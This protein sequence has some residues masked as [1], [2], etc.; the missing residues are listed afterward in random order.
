MQINFQINS[1]NRNSMKKTFAWAL[2]LLT[3]LPLLATASSSSS[4]DFYRF[5]PLLSS[6]PSPN[7]D[8]LLVN[9]WG[10]VITSYGNV[11]VANNGSSTSTI[12]TSTLGGV[13][14]NPGT[15]A[16]VRPTLFINVLSNPTGIVH[17]HSENSFQFGTSSI[18]SKPAEYIYCT[19]EGTILAYNRHVDP[20]NA[21][22]VIDSASNGAVYKG[23]EKAKVDNEYYLYATDFRNGKI[24]VFNSKFKYVK[25]FTDQT[26][27]AGYAPFNIRNFDGKLYVTYA[28]QL[29]PDNE[30][31]DPGPGNGFVN[32]FSL[33]GRF[34]KR[35]VSDGNLN[36]PWGLAIAPKNFGMFSHALLV[37]NFGDGL[38]NAYNPQNGD[39]IGQLFDSTGS[40]IVI[41]GLWGLRF[42]HNNI[43]R[44]QLY[45]TSGPA[46]ETQGL[47]G[48]I[49]FAG[50]D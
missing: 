18:K 5:V 16:P 33:K 8:P 23:L 34:I 3:A 36:S 37:G 38:I 14:F 13:N 31:D 42:D 27:P 19:E 25:S 32:I 39:L 10:F 48:L 45:F 35:L 12:Y 11:V 29:P 1:K 30:D 50:N 41:D 20:L 21:I 40:P 43:D 24:D 15:K 2:I 44:P 22:V 17:N 49:Q 6:F 26:I 9:P 7:S 28:K 46:G 47:M 4:L